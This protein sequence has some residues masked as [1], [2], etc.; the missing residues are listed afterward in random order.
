[1]FYRPLLSTV[2][3]LR[4]RRRPNLLQMCPQV[5]WHRQRRIDILHHLPTEHDR[6]LPSPELCN[7]PLDLGTEGA[8]ET[9]DGPG[10]GVAKGA[11][12]TAFD[13]FAIGG[14]GLVS[15][16]RQENIER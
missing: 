5:I 14:W 13:L 10:S 9:L 12:C 6:A 2:A 11:D 4:T 8:H 15:I 16:R 3:A 7:S 1:M